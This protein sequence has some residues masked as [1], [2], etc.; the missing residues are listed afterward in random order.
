[1]RH[2]DDD[3]DD[4][5]GG[6]ERFYFERPRFGDPTGEPCVLCGGPD[7]THLWRLCPSC[8]RRL[9]ERQ[10]GRDLRRMSPIAV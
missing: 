3:R 10:G 5:G 9:Q 4:D 6:R 7:A 8:R 1:M 2:D